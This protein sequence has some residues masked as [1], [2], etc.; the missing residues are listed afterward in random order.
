MKWVFADSGAW[1]AHLVEEDADH[2]SAVRIFKQGLKERWQLITT[3]AVVFETH[4][5]LLNRARDGRNLALG[6]LND[7]DSGLCHVERVTR[8][9]EEQA[10]Q[11]LWTHIDKDYSLCDA[12]SFVVMERLD[13]ETVV[14]FDKHFYQYG[15]FTVLSA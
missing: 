12:L 1:Y 7:I 15:R 4:A 14:A 2:E 13:A 11:L 3:N 6:F 10:V 8:R 9:D 5:L